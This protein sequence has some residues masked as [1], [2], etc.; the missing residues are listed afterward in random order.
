MICLNLLSSVEK[1]TD[2]VGEDVVEVVEVGGDVGEVGKVV[3]SVRESLYLLLPTLS[4][5]LKKCC[6]TKLI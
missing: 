4:Y 5:D 6:P 2:E 3:G 1:Q